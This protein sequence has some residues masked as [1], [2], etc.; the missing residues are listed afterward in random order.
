MFSGFV[1]GGP[2]T[3]NVGRT[4]SK[5][6]TLRTIDSSEMARQLLALGVQPG[7]VLVVHTAFS[8]VAP[9][10]DGARSLIKALLTALGR[11]GTLVI[12]SMTDDDDHP[13]DLKETPCVGMGVVAD[14]F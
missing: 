11:T 2:L 8:K 5:A 9:L 12:P 13:F 4:N 1:I 10:E 14:T 7:G 3:L 6:M